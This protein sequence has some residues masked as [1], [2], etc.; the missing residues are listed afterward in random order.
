MFSLNP[1]YH[2]SFPFDSTTLHITTHNSD[3]LDLLQYVYNIGTCLPRSFTLKKNQTPGVKLLC[4]KPIR[5]A[6]KVDTLC[7]MF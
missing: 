1:F 5:S 7:H 6:F 2:D 4:Y 3:H